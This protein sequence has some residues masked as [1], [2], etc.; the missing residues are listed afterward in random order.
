MVQFNGSG[1]F[2]VCT[3]LATT[4][5]LKK[6]IKRTLATHDMHS[7]CGL[8][9]GAPSTSLKEKELTMRGK[10]FS[11]LIAATFMGSFASTFMPPFDNERNRCVREGYHHQRVQK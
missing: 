8:C 9:I 5:D 3:H 7:L 2:F 4:N 11:Y 1:D 10:F 6:N